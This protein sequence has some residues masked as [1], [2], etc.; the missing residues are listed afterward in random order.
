[1]NNTGKTTETQRR[2]DLLKSIRKEIIKQSNTDFKTIL[3][4]PEIK[5]YYFGLL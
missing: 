2:N 4:Y 1:M 5:R 3:N